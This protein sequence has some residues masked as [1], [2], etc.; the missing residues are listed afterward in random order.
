MTLIIISFGLF[1]VLVVYVL[2]KHLQGTLRQKE[3]LSGDGSSLVADAHFTAATGALR[4]GN[5][6]ISYYSY[7]N[8]PELVVRIE[9]LLRKCLNDRNL[10]PGSHG[11]V[12]RV[13]VSLSVWR[14]FTALIWITWI[15][16]LILLVWKGILLPEEQQARTFIGSAFGVVVALSILFGIVRDSILTKWELQSDN[17]LIGK[18]KLKTTIPIRQITALTIE[19]AHQKLR[20]QA[21]QPGFVLEVKHDDQNARFYDSR[22]RNLLPLY[23]AIVTRRP[24]LKIV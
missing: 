2:G 8:Q 23:D 16:G 21:W 22:L 20:M 1:I 14:V 5:E 10:F 18:W 24:E 4:I 12:A 6:T 19:I 7:A 13:D 11:K 9:A 3:P 15:S 17:L